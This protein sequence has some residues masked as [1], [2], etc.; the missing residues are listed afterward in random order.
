MLE[1]S[2][3]AYSAFATLTYSDEH[4]PADGSLN[5]L[6]TRY[7]LDRLRKR[8]GYGS[9][10]FYLC[11]EY[12]DS[13]LR[14][15]YHV[16]LFGFPP[17]VHGSTRLDVRGNP[18][19]NCCEPCSVVH[20]TWSKGNI[21]L[22]GLTESSAQYICG[23][24]T[25]KLS[26]NNDPRRQLLNGLHPEFSRQSNRPGIGASAA[27]DIASDMMKFN[28]DQTQADVPSALRHGSRMMPL[29]RY[30]K[31]KIREQIGRVATAPKTVQLKNS[32]KMRPLL[33]A[34]KA[35]SDGTKKLYQEVNRGEFSS[36]EARQKIF[37]QKK[38]QL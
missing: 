18:L 15:H 25:K 12:G 22:G 33:E 28:L 34:Q 11:G 38:D 7:W 21:F 36:F 13:T 5:P 23:Y 30:M 31:G 37:K 20:Q 6:A 4:L 10:R 16:A 27:A 35:T 17:C 2:Q 3:H 14:P 26:G 9:F 19:S 29:G 8:T 24:V 32:E 1:A